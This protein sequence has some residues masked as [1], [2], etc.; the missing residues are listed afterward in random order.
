MGFHSRAIPFNLIREKS[1]ISELHSAHSWASPVNQHKQIFYKQLKMKQLFAK[2]LL[3]PMNRITKLL[4]SILEKTHSSKHKLRSFPIP[5]PP[6]TLADSAVLLSVCPTCLDIS[7]PYFSH[8]LSSP[9]PFPL[10]LAPSSPAEQ[11]QCPFVQ[12]GG[13][14]FEDAWRNKYIRH[15][16]GAVNRRINTIAFFVGK[17]KIQQLTMP[18]FLVNM[19]DFHG[20]ENPLIQLRHIFHLFMETPRAETDVCRFYYSANVPYTCKVPRCQPAYTCTV[21]TRHTLHWP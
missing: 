3:M 18:T 5:S 13:K 6:P 20:W 14:K 4:N 21:Y 11:E 1:I 16:F 10:F 9:A 17:C 7:P 12:R 15:H 19:L 8:C 2:C